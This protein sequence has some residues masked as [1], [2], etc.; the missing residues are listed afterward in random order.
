VIKIR[1]LDPQP[2][3][4]HKDLDLEPE[5][6]LNQECLIGRHPNSGVVLDSAEV[7]RLHGKIFFR[8]GNYYFVD[9]GSKGGSWVNSKPAQPNQSY[10]LQVSDVIRIGQF[11][12]VVIEVASAQAPTLLPLEQL[13]V[14]QS[15]GDSAVAAVAPE[16]AVQNNPLS[17][18]TPTITPSS[19]MPVAMMDPD[20][21][22]RW[23]TK[24]AIA[25]RCA[26]VIEE[27]PD[28]KTFCFVADPPILFTYKP[29]QF[30][31]LELEING[32]QVLRSYSISS[33]PSRP[34]TLEITVK[35]V[36]APEH[37][38]EAPRGL[39]SNWLH[40]NVTVGSEIKL[41]GPLGKFTCFNNPCQKLLL[42][43]AGSGITPMMGMSRWIYDTASD[44][45][46]VFF[47]SARSPR[48]IIFRQELEMMSARSPN[49]H[50][51]VT[52]TRKEPGHSWLGLTG[53][54]SGATLQ[55]VVPDFRD[56]T[57]YVCGPNAFMEGVK[58]TLAG[59]DFPMQNYYEES[60]G[61]KKKK[62]SAPKPDQ[63]KAQPVPDKPE[64]AQQPAGFQTLVRN[65]L[66]PPQPQARSDTSPVTIEPVGASAL[67]SPVPTQSVRSSNPTL[68]FA[69]SG[70]EV[71]C[72]GEDSILDLAE[73]EGV[74]IRSSCRSGVCGTCKKRKLEGEVKM[75]DYELEALEDSERNEGYI[76]TCISYPLGRVVMDA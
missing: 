51:V 5:T 71:A 49:F 20:Q 61:G 28:A 25:V 2:F 32:E 13:G 10:L 8:E 63:P 21:I 73:Q 50:L 66:T 9:L 12:L 33:T 60:F 34:H 11:T 64:P 43:S 58:E 47:H 31:T 22:E 29:G 68:V 57:V 42:I 45:D 3:D 15:N 55:H 72:D 40:E 30:V 75:D 53:R 16:Q 56:R 37:V 39:V 18:L 26:R 41:S 59:L 44:C 36:P 4:E 14:P 67:P 52:T 35:R 54:F 48:D 74:K 24:D 65:L 17:V 27:T 19:Y 70:K 76:L 7:S 62:S 6:L 38:P 1:V 46:V 69:K 23:R